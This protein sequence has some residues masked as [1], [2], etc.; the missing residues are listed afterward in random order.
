MGLSTATELKAAIAS[1]LKRGDLTTQIP[2]FITLAEIAIER[3]LGFGPGVTQTYTTSATLTASQDWIYAPIG[4]IEPV[5]LRLES[6]PER[7]LGVVTLR[8]LARKR[9]VNNSGIPEVM[10]Q[11]GDMRT[12]TI[13]AA[14][15]QSPEVRFTSTAHGLLAGDRVY[16]TGTADT[17]YD[18]RR[19]VYDVDTDW[20]EV[21]TT[22]GATA[23]GTW[24]TF[25]PKIMFDTAPSGATDYTLFYKARFEYLSDTEV[26]WLL[27]EHPDLILYGALVTASPYLKNDERI[28]MWAG[29]FQSGLEAARKQQWRKRT[30]GGE[31]RMRPDVVP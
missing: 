8:E 21:T 14:A 7:E 4:C 2:D 9:R 20:F 19:L 17:N 24:K 11:V 18:G 15:D 31:L 12:G 6:D 25:Q 23:T 27:S 29:F 3:E 16:I 13:T 1:W 26:T 22:W 5:F 28:P 30:S 10:A